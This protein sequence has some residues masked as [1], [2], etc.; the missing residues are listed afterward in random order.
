MEKIN[1]SAQGHLEIILSFTLFIGALIFLF[2]IINPFAEVREVS[3]INKFQE[4]II[5]EMS[6]EIGKLG[7]IVDSIDA[8]YEFNSTDYPENYAEAL[9]DSRKYNIYFGEIFTNTSLKKGCSPLNYSLGIYSS[10]KIIVYEKVE[11]LV[12]DYNTDYEGLKTSLG[13]ANDFAF[14]FRNIIN[15]DVT[16]LNV[17][18]QAPAGVD[19]EAKELPV[20]VIDS[21][22]NIQELILQIRAW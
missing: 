2:L 21:N 9:E 16:A 20:R 18:R 19:V 22:A 10:E 17:T 1:K 6:L 13:I 11:D 4:K 8:C 5:N 3:I 15:R 7:V 12:T 14:S